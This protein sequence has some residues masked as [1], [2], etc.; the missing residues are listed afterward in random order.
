MAS[1]NGT[2]LFSALFSAFIGFA[3]KYSALTDICIGLIISGR[4]QQELMNIMGM[5]AHT[6]PFR[7]K[8]DGQWT[9][10]QLLQ[11]V[12]SGLTDIY[13]N[14]FLPEDIQLGK[15]FDVVITHQSQTFQVNRTISVSN[16]L[17][18]CPV[19]QEDIIARFPLVFN[20]YEDI[21]SILCE[22]DHNKQAYSPLQIDIITKKFIR[23]I[24]GVT[25]DAGQCIA[26]HSLLLEEEINRKK[27]IDITFNF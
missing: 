11:N 4:D 27:N 22:L 9:F 25:K 15:F 3:H 12:S 19:A 14:T 18:L 17:S 23:F 21:D 13:Q 20:F 8:V 6:A 26:D 24:E 7:I 16:R 10:L 2:T 5:M 1:D